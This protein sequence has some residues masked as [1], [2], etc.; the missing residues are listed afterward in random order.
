MVCPKCGSES[1]NVQAVAHVKNKKKGCLYWCLIGFWLEPIM[2]LFFTLPM[3]FI[4]LFGKSKV[5]TKVK[6]HAVCQQC[7]YQWQL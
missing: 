4:K 6:S 3:I 2:W 7:G 1:V 5:K